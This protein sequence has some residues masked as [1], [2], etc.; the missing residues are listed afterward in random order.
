M[1]SVGPGTRA[2]DPMRI[3]LQV[4]RVGKPALRL[5]PPTGA[6]IGIARIDDNPAP[7]Q[8]SPTTV[9]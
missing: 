3:L 1:P 6:R 4:G 7:W 8:L 5:N 2:A 9:L